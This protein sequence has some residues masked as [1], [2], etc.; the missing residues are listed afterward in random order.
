[1]ERKTYYA[2]DVAKFIS[3]FLVVCIH[4]GPLLDVDATG[5]FILVQILARLAVPFFFVASGFL[6][7]RKLDFKREYNDYENKAQLKH[8]LWRLCKIYIIW[9]ILYLPFTYLLLKGQD[10]ITVNSVLL[11]VRDFFFTGSFYHLWF[12]P[13]LL[14]AVPVVYICLFKLG[15]GKTILFGFLLYLIGMAGNVYGGLSDADSGDTK[16][17]SGISAGIFHNTQRPVLRRDVYRYGGPVCTADTV[18]EKLAGTAGIP[19]QRRT[20]VCG[21]LRTER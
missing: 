4:T 1:M 19:A 6:F 7:F 15:L 5:N 9:T 8:Y 20:A 17:I 10:G 18:P 3:A 14:V 16:R 2:L 11:Y 12:L 13:A 21:M